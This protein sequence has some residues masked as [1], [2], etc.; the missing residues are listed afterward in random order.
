MYDE[1]KT[2]QTKIDDLRDGLHT[3]PVKSMGAGKAKRKHMPGTF[4]QFEW[5]KNK[6]IQVIEKERKNKCYSFIVKCMP[7]DHDNVSSMLDDIQEMYKKDVYWPK[8]EKG[9]I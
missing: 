7:S 3:A 8:L 2:N 5:I 9:K 1:N 4:D 6:I